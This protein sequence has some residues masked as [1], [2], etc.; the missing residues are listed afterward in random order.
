MRKGN[1]FLKFPLHK[2]FQEYC[3]A[4]YITGLAESNH[5]VFL[6][7]IHAIADQENVLKFCC[8]LSTRAAYF[9]LEHVVNELQMDN[10]ADSQSA[11]GSNFFDNTCIL[12]TKSKYFFLHVCFGNFK[13]NNSSHDFS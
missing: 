8:G 4:V 11:S 12:P 9:I 5:D 10:T 2:S 3:A 6:S 13:D 1:Q 7:N